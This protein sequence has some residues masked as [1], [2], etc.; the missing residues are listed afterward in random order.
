[1]ATTALP[2]CDLGKPLDLGTADFAQRK[3]DW[4]R[5]LLEEAPV[6]IGK[7]S[8]LKVNL[9][10]RYDDCRMVL[11]DA[12]F[13]RNQGVA[14]GKPATA[15]PLPIPLPKSVKALA[16]SMIV[17]DDPAHRRLR[18]LVNR[19]FTPRAVGTLSDRVE[20]LSHELLDGLA[21]QRRF[22][23]LEHYA[24]PIPLRVIAEMMGI[25]KEQAAELRKLTQVLTKGLSGLNVVKT[26]LWDL[27]GTSEFVRSLVAQKRSAPGDDILSGLIHAEEEGDRL[28]EEEL[29]AMVFLVIIGGFETTQHMITNGVRELL[30]KPDSLERLRSEPE[31]WDLAVDELVRHRG[32]VHATKPQYATEDVELHGV[33][34]K[35]GTPIM[36]LLG[37]A[38]HDPRAFESPDQLDITRS[39]NRHLGFGFGMHFCLGAQ[40]ARM[41]TRIG[42][43]NLVERFPDLRLDVDPAALE[44]APMPG[45][46]RHTSLPVTHG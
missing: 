26:L 39:P 38:N 45:W 46:H 9:L 43:K 13:V 23:L 22:D 3:Y 8:V 31:L 18:N 4:Y 15:S 34:I 36:P 33:T 40:L 21:K 24:F 30:E 27:R 10:A 7:I 32:P 2:E 16:A 17:Q 5:F 1:V 41:E 19:A 11:N 42:I 37:A 44:I 14:K 29:V 25:P 12:R 6:S 20:D 28:S 35:R